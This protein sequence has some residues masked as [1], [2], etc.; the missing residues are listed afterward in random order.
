VYLPESVKGAAASG[1]A[2]TGL[3]RIE[4]GWVAYGLSG[5]ALAL[6]FECPD[7][8]QARL[9]IDEAVRK[10]LG[11]W[12]SPTMMMPTSS[13]PQDLR[14]VRWRRLTAPFAGHASSTEDGQGPARPGRSATVAVVRDQKVLGPHEVDTAVL[15][16]A[17]T[18]SCRDG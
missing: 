9:L 18:R 4:D 7:R 15:W 10:L 17:A 8:E 2:A 3:A 5:R 1:L 6:A 12:R 11:N 14:R 16:S 13:D